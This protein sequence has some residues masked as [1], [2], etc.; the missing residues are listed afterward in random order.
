MK[1]YSNDDSINILNNSV[2][3]GEMDL[4]PSEWYFLQSNLNLQKLN[5]I[6]RLFFLKDTRR[7][8]TSR[9]KQVD[10][11]PY[12]E[13]EL[14]RQ[15]K[16]NILQKQLAGNVNPRKMI[17]SKGVVKKKEDK[18]SIKKRLKKI[19]LPRHPEPNENRRKNGNTTAIARGRT[20]QK[21]DRLQK[22]AGKPTRDKFCQIFYQSMDKI[23]RLRESYDAKVRR[24]YSARGES[25]DSV[26]AR[27]KRNKRHGNS[28]LAKT[29]VKKWGKVFL[30]NN[31]ISDIKKQ[32]KGGDSRR[33]SATETGRARRNSVKGKLFG[34]NPRKNKKQLKRYKLS[35]KVNNLQ[36]LLEYLN[37]VKNLDSQIQKNMSKLDNAGRSR[38][39]SDD[40]SSDNHF[41][42]G[43]IQS[44]N[45]VKTAPN[46][47]AQHKIKTSN[48]D[49]NI[50]SLKSFEKHENRA[51]FN[52]NEMKM[53]KSIYSGRRHAE[54]QKTNDGLDFSNSEIFPRVS[55]RVQSDLKQLFPS[56]VEID[57]FSKALDSLDSHQM[58]VLSR[59]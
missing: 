45:H 55:N 42:F 17:F 31:Y 2:D 32:L 13:L 16:E 57:A 20:P 54:E 27:L 10:M 3:L 49:L 21:E 19:A 39:H 53:R 30:K 1:K 29:S 34:D 35:E 50:C 48:P 8:T 47:A 6:N 46:P 43:K 15:D 28:I 7:K 58:N 51:F 9:A 38:K 33:N 5:Y 36:E 56:N 14:I 25:A 41:T 59:E 12:S 24:K 22:G 26:E 52:Q 18:E 44:P 40:G 4:F 11:F 23:K 37:S